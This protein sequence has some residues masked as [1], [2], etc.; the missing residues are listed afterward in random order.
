MS[1]NKYLCPTP[2]EHCTGKTTSMNNFFNQPKNAK[3][4]GTPSAAFDC[5]VSFLEKTGHQRLAQRE[6]RRPEGGI[7]LL[8]KRSRFGTKVR[9][10]KEGTRFMV[11]KH[12]G[13][14]VSS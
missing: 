13:C 2:R 6:F 9:L 11:L 3:L 4:H 5:Y 10:G 14:M 8:T 7:L 12:N 1:A